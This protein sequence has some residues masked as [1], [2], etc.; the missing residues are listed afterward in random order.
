MAI[1]GDTVCTTMKRP[2][3][4]QKDPKQSD[5]IAGDKPT[6]DHTERG[7]V[8]HDHIVME[9]G[10]YVQNNFPVGYVY[11]SMDS[12]SPAALYG[13]SWEKLDRVMLLAAGG[14]ITLGTTGGEWQH[15]LTHS[16]LP[17]HDHEGI[18]YYG[19][20]VN[21]NSGSVSGTKSLRF[22]TFQNSNTASAE[23]RTGK[24]GG[25]KPHNNMPPYVAVNMWKRVA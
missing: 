15:T 13:G 24:S 12:T 20:M 21:L 14:E 18:Y 2:N 6:I 1:T 5:F 3:W 8:S 7:N 25:N 11:I 4:N 16:E 23:L 22:G 17:S 10:K 9:D 19:E